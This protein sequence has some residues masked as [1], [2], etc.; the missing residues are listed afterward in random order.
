MAPG[1]VLI[2]GF[3]DHGARTYADILGGCGY[4]AL[5]YPSL[6]E[7]L[8]RLETQT[9]HISGIILDG[10]LPGM[11]GLEFM[12]LRQDIARQWPVILATSQGSITVAVQ[13]MQLGAANFVV[14]PLSPKRVPQIVEDAGE[15]HRIAHPLLETG[16]PFQKKSDCAHPLNGFQGFVGLSTPMTSIYEKIAL[17][18]QSRATVFITGESGTGKEVC[19]EAIHSAGPRASKAFIAVNC[20][21]IPEGLL[22]SE[23]FGHVR[24]G[25][26]G[27][28][29]DRI[30]AVQ[31]AEGGTLFLDEIC[32]MPLS[33]QVK[34]LR[35]LQNGTV[36][37]VGE[38]RT[39]SVN[40]RII[41]ATNRNPETEVAEGRFREDLY[42][43]LNVVPIEMPPLRARGH[44]IGLI[45]N[46]LLER[47]ATEEAKSFSRLSPEQCRRL[48][49]YHWP[50]NVRELQNH[51]RRLAVMNNGPAIPD[52]AFDFPLSP[53]WE[54]PEKH[55]TN[56]L[57]SLARPLHRASPDTDQWRGMTMDEVERTVIERAIHDVGGSLPLAA[58]VLGM[59]PSTL[60]R[61]RERWGEEGRAA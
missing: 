42:Y 36:Q 12:R 30:G 23:L 40:V 49:A 59:S 16:E 55:A 31:A 45:A 47:Y 26:T 51:I 29:S 46:V 2:V 21:A 3:T 48:A 37:R 1:S 9:D 18:A 54:K 33:L 7:F 4:T 19:A 35:F 14:K 13:A 27:A 53:L 50:G 60:Y 39:T 32:E 20:G 43:R 11:C 25:F 10:E 17:L 24:G 56:A 38:A 5:I 8:D 28:I 22:E 41:C 52:D 57:L 58:R 61:K 34:L 44:D 15:A 6:T